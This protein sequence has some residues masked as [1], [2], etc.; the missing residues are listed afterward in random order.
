[1]TGRFACLCALLMLTSACAEILGIEEPGDPERAG[2]G[3]SA[4]SDG[5]GAAGSN[6]VAGDGGAGETGIGGAGCIPTGALGLEELSISTGV[7]EPEF[8]ASGDAYHVRVGLSVAE[9]SVTPVAPD[10]CT[11]LV[12]G[13]AVA[14]GD[15]S[16][17]IPLVLSADASATTTITVVTDSGTADEKTYSIVVERASGL[18][19]EDYLKA[20]NFLAEDHFGAKVALSQGTLAVGAPLQD[21]SGFGVDSLQGDNATDNAGAVYVF[22]KSDGDWIQQAYLKASNPHEFDRFGTAIALSGDV[23]VVGA[24]GESS[25]AQRVNGEMNDASVV[26]SGAAYVFQR[27]AGHWAQSAYLKAS[28]NAM[29][30]AFGSSV[31]IAGNTIVVGAPSHAQPPELDHA[32]AAYVFDRV[33]YDW[34]ESHMLA[35]SNPAASDGFGASVAITSGRIVVGA[36]GESS[37]ATGVGGDE[38]DDSEDYSGSGAAYVFDWNGGWG[39]PTYLKASNTQSEAGFGSAVAID[40]DLVA[41]GA[42]NQ[43]SSEASGSGAVYV[44]ASGGLEGWEQKALIEGS[45]GEAGDGFGSAVALGQG[46]LAVAAT[47]EDSSAVGIDGD[48]TNN[49]ADDSGAVYLFAQEGDGWAQ[50]AFVKAL[51]T[52]AKDH[53]GSAVATA[54]GELAIGAEL[55][56]GGNADDGSD[57]STLASGAV[58]VR[59]L[60]AL[61]PADGAGAPGLSK[62]EVGDQ[63]LALSPTTFDYQ[64]SVA[65]E[66]ATVKLSMTAADP[67]AELAVTDL[68][69]ETVDASQDIGLHSGDNR[70]TIHVVATS[71]EYVTYTVNV[72]LPIPVTEAV[73]DGSPLDVSAGM[74]W[75]AFDDSRIPVALSVDTLVVGVPYEDL[76]VDASYDYPTTEDTGTAFVFEH[77]V[78]G[79]NNDYP[80]I[81][82]ASNAAGANLFGAAV[83]VDGDT[84]VVGAPGEASD[85]QVVNGDETQDPANAATGAAYVFMRDPDSKVW[86]Q[87]A[88]LKAFNSHKDAEFGY[89]VAIDG[90]RIVVGARGESDLA[91]GVDDPS[92]ATDGASNSGAAYVFVRI[93]QTWTPEAYLKP[94]NTR[95]EQRF[96]TRVAMLGDWIAV[97]ASGDGGGSSTIDGDQNIPDDQDIP[98]EAGGSGAV[99]TFHL[100]GSGWASESYIKAPNYHIDVDFGRSLALGD[101]ILAVGA[102]GDQNRSRYV[103]SDEF[104]TMAVTVTYNTDES[105]S[106]RGAVYVFEREDDTPWH[107]TAYLKASNADLQDAFGRSVSLSGD[108]LA[109]GAPRESSWFFGTPGNNAAQSSGAAYLFQRSAL[110]WS[111][112][113]YV[114]PTSINPGV[115]FG[116]FVALDDGAPGTLVAGNCRQSSP[117]PFVAATFGKVSVFQF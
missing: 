73:I 106:G 33:G 52:Q 117:E 80:A 63:T 18:F 64:V 50:Q 13:E 48:Q 82:K 67:A 2:S 87:Q 40:G 83:A 43:S 45:N 31:A 14:S 19:S 84:L 6:A 77:S 58:Y 22:V 104:D 88:Y 42:P 66:T 12:N 113:S 109:V 65:P 102:A 5:V 8:S 60:L 108:Y 36:P 75:E 23:L 16:Q 101:N 116:C 49:D 85:A 105:I 39:T 32:G 100:G 69:G 1:M 68:W 71:G 90:D 34:V 55:E 9:L 74:L 46:V 44:F 56:D 30:N 99:F 91:V 94:S 53:F 4:G 93:G 29:N 37:A 11:I 89:S 61:P 47:G 57:N 95:Q 98:N 79:W 25:A 110:G 92:P 27:V 115:G 96:G 76:A 38:T 21:S 26:F 35:A 114:K 41:V 107:K 10:R 97:T 51:N 62:L 3:G 24:P 111:Q 7:L 72:Q 59:S 15:A 86:L 78:G 54:D 70:F 81:L 28:G 17:P 103:N 112:A 20:S